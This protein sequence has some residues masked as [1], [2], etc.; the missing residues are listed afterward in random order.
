M[1]VNQLSEIYRAWV[2]LCFFGTLPSNP[3][4]LKSYLY[5]SFAPTFTLPDCE[6][7]NPDILLC[8]FCLY[9]LLPTPL[10]CTLNRIYTHF[11]VLTYICSTWIK[12]LHL[13]LINNIPARC[14]LISTINVC[15]ELLL[16]D[17]AF[18]SFQ[19]LLLRKP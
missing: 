1:I 7:N 17:K 16:S 19:W 6:G 9:N 15:N 18:L 14:K 12:L 5:P 13:M 8:Q 10:P 11:V 4:F 2:N 3:L